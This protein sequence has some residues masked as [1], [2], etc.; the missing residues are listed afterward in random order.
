METGQQQQSARPPLPPVIPGPSSCNVGLPIHPLS[1][2]QDKRSGDVALSPSSSSASLVRHPR[3]PHFR[4]P[5][6]PSKTSEA[7]SLPPRIHSV[8]LRYTVC[9]ERYRNGSQ[10][11]SPGMT[12][13]VDAPRIDDVARAWPVSPS[14]LTHRTPA[15]CNPETS[16]VCHCAQPEI[17]LSLLV[18]LTVR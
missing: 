15:L 7:T 11:R 1:L 17:L 8:I 4:H 12:N 14:L 16:T 18:C 13:E 9:L 3:P 5:R 6:P 10:G 2:R